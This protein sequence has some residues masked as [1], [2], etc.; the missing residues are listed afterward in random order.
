MG[1]SYLDVAHETASQA[2]NSINAFVDISYNLYDGGEKG[3]KYKSYESQIK[4]SKEDL[5]ALK[6]KIT[7]DVVE[8][9]FDYLG[10][11]ASKQAKQKE[12]EQLNAQYKRLSKFFDAGTTTIDELDKIISKVESA[13]LQLHE[14]DLKIQTVLH[15]LEYITGQ[16]VSIHEGS[17]LQI[18]EEEA[19][20]RNDIK[21][22]KSSMQ[23]QLLNAKR[24]KTADN[25]QVDLNNKYTYYDN[26]YSSKVYDEANDL[27]DQNV[28]A[29]NVK[30]NLFDFGAT[31]TA[32]SAAHK[33][34]LSTKSKYE[35]ERN[36][37]EVDLKLA[38]KAYDIAKLK[39]KSANSALRAAISTYEVTKNKFEN[40][41]V[42]NVTYL[43]ALS[44]KSE[45]QSSLS[46]SKYN[47][48]ITKANVMYQKGKNVW[49]YVK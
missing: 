27:E 20:L 1:G 38:L 42:D 22:L 8:Y 19:Q 6:N 43:E 48:E 24:V 46:L 29:L 17:Y 26:N 33:S 15:E 4:T 9:Y 12:I 36:K 37:A 41:L 34:F 32:Y 23:T 47:L 35:Y 10:Y 39:I 7:L 5:E 40:G 11:I 13:N 45:A 28:F 44:E 49:E 3:L 14:L 30:W 25:P 16:K 18:T 2:N 31:K 21:A